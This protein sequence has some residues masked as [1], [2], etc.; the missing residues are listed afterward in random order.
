MTGIVVVVVVGGTV[1]EVVL[2]V[3]VVVV[4]GA[5]VV[6]AS[7][8]SPTLQE[9]MIM[10]RARGSTRTRRFICGDLARGVVASNDT[11]SPYGSY[12]QASRPK[13]VESLQLD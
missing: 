13:A 8:A 11:V 3:E 2:E 7:S 5:T 4:V 1:V 9:A 6:V 10:L 12:R